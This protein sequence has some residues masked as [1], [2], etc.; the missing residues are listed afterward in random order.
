MSAKP[1]SSSWA[2]Y[3]NKQEILQSHDVN[4]LILHQET[5]LTKMIKVKRGNAQLTEDTLNDRSNDDDEANVS[6]SSSEEDIF[7]L[8]N[9]LQPL[10]PISPHKQ[11]LNTDLN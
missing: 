5:P 3:Y 4:D 1:P 7:N 11:R 10:M 2:C 6:S 9:R 8:A